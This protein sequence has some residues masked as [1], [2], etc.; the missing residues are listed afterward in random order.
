MKKIIISLVFVLAKF[1]L[2]AQTNIGFS[3]SEITLITQ[4]GN[5]YGTI[6]IP[7]SIMTSPI[8]LIIPGSGS[9]DR[10]GNCIPIGLHSNNLKMLSESLAEKGIST[11]RFDKRGAGKSKQIVTSESELRFENYIDDVVGWISLLKKDKRFPDITILGHSEGSLIG[12]IA[13]QQTNITS[14]IS[15]AGVGKSADRLLQAQLKQLPPQLLSESNKIIDSLK[16]GKTVSKVNPNLIRI[17]RPSVQPYLISWMKYDPANEIAKLKIPTLI[18]QGT[19]DL[20]VSV[21]DA[22]LLLEAKAASK[23]VIIENMN[24]FLKE[25]GSDIQENLATY[26]NPELPLKQ[27]IVD[28]IVSFVKIK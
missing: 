13:A 14:F 26:R 6:T 1:V 16:V 21:D 11:L 20:Q 12:M 3:E 15:V 28:E 4:S 7:K 27:E 8:V 18:I 19:T 2:L 17:F 24:H 5:L 9:P 23:L 25:S 22:K 10:D